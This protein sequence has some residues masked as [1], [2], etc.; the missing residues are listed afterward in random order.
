[1]AASFAHLLSF[2][3]RALTA[4]WHR[5]E[6]LWYENQIVDECYLAARERVCVL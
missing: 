5:L 2:R 3:N 6:V 1:M 4:K